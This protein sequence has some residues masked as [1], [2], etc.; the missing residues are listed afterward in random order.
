YI[1]QDN[2]YDEVMDVS[3]GTIE[4]DQMTLIELYDHWVMCSYFGIP[5]YIGEYPPLLAVFSGFTEIYNDKDD[6]D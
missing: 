3:I 6:A 4:S 5:A 1:L 2:V